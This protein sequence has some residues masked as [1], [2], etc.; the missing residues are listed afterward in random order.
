MGATAGLYQDGLQTVIRRR[1]SLTSLVLEVTGNRHAVVFHFFWM[2]FSLSL[3]VSALY[4]MLRIEL[5]VALISICGRLVHV[6]IMAM[7]SCASHSTIR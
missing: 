3:L 1:S 4:V 5:V 7:V 6:Q 2:Y